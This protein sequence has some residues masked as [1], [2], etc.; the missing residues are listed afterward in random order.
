MISTAT[1]RL[2]GYFLPVGSKVR[3]IRLMQRRTASAL[4][5]VV[6]LS[7]ERASSA[8]SKELH[9]ERSWASLLSKRRP[10]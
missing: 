1:S 9:E 8:A 2:V 4:R 6:A 7:S 5:R 10:D 3:L